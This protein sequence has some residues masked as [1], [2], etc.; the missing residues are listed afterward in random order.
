MSKQVFLDFQ[1]TGLH[2][3]DEI[4]QIGIVDETGKIIMDTLIKPKANE[5]W[6]EAQPLHGISPRHV[7]S[8][9]TL[10]EVLPKLVKALK[11]RQVVI[12][13]ADF[14]MRFIPDEAAEAAESFHCAMC[15]FKR[16][17]PET[18][19]RLVDAVDWAKALTRSTPSKK[20]YNAV[21]HARNT[22]FV[23][24]ALQDFLGEFEFAK[25]V[26]KCKQRYLSREEKKAANKAGCIGC[27]AILVVIIILGVLFLGSIPE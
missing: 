9:P 6:P 17:V 18:P 16:T 7:K 2:F 23:W 27:L 25:C 11:D 4:L 24:E 19:H 12:F 21:S 20:Q 1:T 15:M 14:D 26:R 5:I 10:E 8:S 22:L 3:D 13:N